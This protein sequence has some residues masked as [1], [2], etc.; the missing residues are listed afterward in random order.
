MLVFLLFYVLY[1]VINALSGGADLLYPLGW[2]A[3]FAFLYHWV[4]VLIVR[5]MNANIAASLMTGGFFL[6]LLVCIPLGRGIRAHYASIGES[7]VPLYD[8]AVWFCI[9]VLTL[10]LGIWLELRYRRKRGLSGTGSPAGA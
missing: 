9:V 7:A 1:L 2:A 10:A 5:L 4:P 3:N 6:G 8:F